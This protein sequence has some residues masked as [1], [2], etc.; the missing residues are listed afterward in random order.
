MDVCVKVRMKGNLG[1][2]EISFEHERGGLPAKDT[3]EE[4]LKK[5]TTLYKELT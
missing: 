1:E 5:A 4:T 2:I 3:L